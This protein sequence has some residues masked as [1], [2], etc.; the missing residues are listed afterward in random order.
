M[1]YKLCNFFNEIN[2]EYLCLNPHDK[3]LEMIE[4]N[5][6]QLNSRCWYNLCLNPHNK[7]LELVKNNIDKLTTQYDYW[8][9]LCQN[10]NIKV[11]EILSINI[12]QLNL[13]CWITLIESENIFKIKFVINNLEKNN[14]LSDDKDKILKKLCSC[15]I[16]FDYN[17]HQLDKLNQSCWL[18]ICSNPNNNA[19]EIIKSHIIPNL[20]NKSLDKIIKNDKICYNS[21]WYALCRNTNRLIITFII[22]Q[23]DYLIES[24]IIISTLYVISSNSNIGLE[25]L[26]HIYNKTLSKFKF[27]NHKQRKKFIYKLLNYLSINKNKDIL[28]YFF[29]NKL[30]KYT[31]ISY[32]RD[33]D[34][35]SLY[36][37][38]SSVDL[39]CE[40]FDKYINGIHMDNLLYDLL[41][42]P[43]D[44]IVD[45]IIENIDRL[46]YISINEEIGLSALCENTN[47]RIFDILCKKFKKIS[48]LLCHEKYLNNGY[49][50]YSNPFIFVYDYDEMKTS[51][52]TLHNELRYYIMKPNRILNNLI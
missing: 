1:I 4:N 28:N 11:L 30:N 12:N 10:S 16:V 36:Y 26:K 15:K 27:D 35:V 21:F 42:N 46:I 47:K 40:Y 8:Y 6:N 51:K 43:D 17:Y 48:N 38:S 34:L 24:K 44:K 29:K 23:L 22:E 31:E 37:N 32:T 52:I 49:Y 14:I 50:L 25:E 45:K 20:L 3:A 39:I 19:I 18:K 5:I 41:S 9:R 2:Y 7:A 33:K 13:N